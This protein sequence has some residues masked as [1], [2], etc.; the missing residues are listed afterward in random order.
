M[1]SRWLWLAVVVTT[2]GSV[3]LLWA[4]GVPLGVPGEWTWP[5]IPCSVETLTGWCT[6]G[7]AGALYVGLAWLGQRRLA[8]A[9]R[10]EVCGWL[11]ALVVAAFAW[12]SI[13]QS[14]VPGTAGL[15]RI[16]FVLYYPRSSGYFFQA[17]YDV[18]D[19]RD[20]LAGYETL[21]AQ[22]DYLHI[23]THPPGLTWAFRGLLRLCADTPQLVE[24][25]NWSQPADVREAV[26]TIRSQTRLTDHPCTETDAACLWLA[27][28][29][30]QVLA[31]ATVVPLYLLVHRSLDRVGAWQAAVFWP[32]VPAVAVFLPKSD[33]GFPFLALLTAWFWLSGW[34]RRSVL[35]CTCAGL[36]LFSGMLLT[37]AF[38]PVGAILGAW[39]LL[40]CVWGGRRSEVEGQAP[41]VKGQEAGGRRQGDEVGRGSCN[42]LDSRLSTFN[43]QLSTLI[44]H[45]SSLIVLATAGF[46]A[47]LLALWLVYDLNLLN[48]WRWNVLNHALFYEHNV[49]TWWKWLL[50][51]PLEVLFAVGAPLAVLAATGLYRG[52][53]QHPRSSVALAVALV[54]GLLWL[55]GKNMGEAARLW[56][57]LL[58][59]TSVL[60]ASPGGRPGFAA[61]ET[62]PRAAGWLSPREWTALLAL[63]C[64]VCIVTVTRVDGFHFDQL[65]PHQAATAVDSD[66]SV[67]AGPRAT[68]TSLRSRPFDLA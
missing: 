6:A 28:L 35:R 61:A 7:L 32:L 36:S 15:S 68:A 22:R 57:F 48:V 16:P 11:G 47:P 25:L 63:Q 39:T 1:K 14:A 12:L 37:L 8:R 17:R 65:L 2:V 31:A 58:P 9:G 67:C 19:T 56:L 24:F 59:W 40:D 53:A 44:S 42:S 64:A 21:L 30:V 3:G 62:Q 18:E 46:I 4:T 29:L 55:S 50:V 26:A 33:A 5:R 43:S 38:V 60:A 41:G 49:R 52:I 23:G 45:P 13:V 66:A 34:S 10:V 20:F 54:W 51:N 27:A